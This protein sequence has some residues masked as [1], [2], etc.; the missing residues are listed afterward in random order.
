MTGCPP[1]TS[2]CGLRVQLRLAAAVPSCADRLAV[3]L[4]LPG[5]GVTAIFGPS[6]AGKT[7]LLRAIAGLSAAQGWVTLGGQSWQSPQHRLPAHRRRIGYVFQ[8]CALFP[9]LTVRG[10]LRYAARRAGDGAPG[11]DA[12]VESLELGQLLNRRPQTLSGGE[13]QRVAIARALLVG[14]ALLLLDEPLSALDPERRHQLLPYL[15]RLCRDQALPVLYVTHRVYEVARLA[16][17]V[18]ELRQGRVARQGTVRDVL[19][20]LR[21]DHEEPGALIEAQVV[22]QDA[23]WG[24]LRAAFAGGALWVDGRLGQPGAYL[25]LQV[26]ARDVSLSRDPE[27][28]SSLLNRLPVTVEALDAPGDG[29]DQLVRLRAGSTPLLARVTRR[30]VA[31]LGL[32]SGDQLW[33]QIKAVAVLR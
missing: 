21:G 10:N 16:D 30:S 17:Y 4:Q 24:L 19:P 26:Q 15:D 5:R 9:H 32:C 22:E 8:D 1:T 31:E 28:R 7:T 6:G 33:A 11:F 25:R 27:A 20:H 12:V 14:P 29:P 3:D 2:P 23:R 18:V 13:R